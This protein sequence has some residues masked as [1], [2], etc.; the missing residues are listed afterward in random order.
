MTTKKRKSWRDLVEISQGPSLDKIMEV[1]PIMVRFGN[2][3]NVPVCEFGSFRTTYLVRMNGIKIEADIIPVI[4]GV[5]H[6][7]DGHKG[8]S[9][10]GAKVRIKGY[11]SY[12]RTAK[13]FQIFD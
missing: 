4:T 7:E 12:K 3:I 10:N 8:I 5:L 1:I 2:G 11:D 6:Y 9:L 13:S